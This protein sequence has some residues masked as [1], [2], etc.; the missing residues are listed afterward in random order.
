MHC[1]PQ[2]QAIDPAAQEQALRN[3]LGGFGFGVN[4]MESVA[5]LSGGEQ[6]RLVL[7]LLAWQKPALLLLDEPTNHLD[8]EMRQALAL[9]LAEF[10]GA[11]VLVS[12]DMRL[13][14]QVILHSLLVVRRGDGCEE[15][16]FASSI[17]Q[18]AR[19]MI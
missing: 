5:Y 11:V 18:Q 12:H 2:L 9:A 19:G 4:A 7:A 8:M 13:I 1:R 16:T 14:S 3:H 10:E 17:L 15:L 6:A